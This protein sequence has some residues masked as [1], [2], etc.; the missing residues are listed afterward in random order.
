MGAIT[1]TWNRLRPPR[2]SPEATAA[3]VLSRAEEIHGSG[4]TPTFRAAVARAARG[5]FD[6]GDAH[7]G[8]TAEVIERVA[9]ERLYSEGR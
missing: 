6:S 3:A 5:L 2:S 4:A 8:L 1:T 7:Q 9:L